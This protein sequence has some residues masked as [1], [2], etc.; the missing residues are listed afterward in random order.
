MT[1]YSPTKLAY[2][3]VFVDAFTGR[4]YGD[5]IENNYINIGARIVDLEEGREELLPSLCKHFPD[6]EVWTGILVQP[7]GGWGKEDRGWRREEGRGWL[8]ERDGGRLSYIFD[9]Y[10]NCQMA[11]CKGREI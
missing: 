3:T 5:I 7:V 6:K 8:R 4:N 1:F 11:P 9:L 2:V 10:R